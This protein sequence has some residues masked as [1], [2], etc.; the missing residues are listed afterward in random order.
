[1]K[2][3]H[4]SKALQEQNLYEFRRQ[5]EYKCKKNN[6]TL[7]IADRF[8][9]SSKKCC[10]CGSIEKDLKLKERTYHC[11]VYTN[12]IDKIIRQ[13]LTINLKVL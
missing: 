10:K 1:M 13:V 11:K 12:R 7:R 3:R 8:Y 2:N 4:L 6:I 5:L 9:P